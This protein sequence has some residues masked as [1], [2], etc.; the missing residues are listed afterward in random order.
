MRVVWFLNNCLSL[1]TVLCMIRC[2]AIL[3]S[4]RYLWVSPGDIPLE[5]VQQLEADLGQNEG[6]DHPLQPHVMPVCRP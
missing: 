4:M 1:P 6:Y 3:V 2:V 5:E